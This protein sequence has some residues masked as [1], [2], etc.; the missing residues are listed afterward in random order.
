[1]EQAN[2][3][4]DSLLD[5]S[6]IKE[7]VKIL[8][9]NN[10][11]CGAI[12]SIYANQL[13]FFFLDVLNVYKVYSEHI[14]ATIAQHGP[15]ATQ[16]SLVRTMRG[17]KKE[18]LRLL[19]VF[20]NSS[21]PPEADPHAVAQG[22]IPPVLEP[23]L[24]DYKNNIPNARDPEVLALF[25]TVVEKL[26]GHILGDVPRIMDAVFESTLEMITTNF[27]D[28]PEHRLRFFEFI[29]VSTTLSFWVYPTPPH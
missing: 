22:F 16:L 25:T 4:V 3:S 28:Y 23:I 11:T 6:I 12:G 24:G 2:S 21:G 1:M 13:Q 8:K 7:I 27:E 10:K 5:P 15:S 9:I 19:I 18:I 17:A 29:R 14:S 20:I 26:K